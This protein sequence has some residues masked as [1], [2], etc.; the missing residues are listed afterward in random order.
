MI[1]IKEKAWA[2]RRADVNDYYV[3]TGKRAAGLCMD[4]DGCVLF[5]PL[6][7]E[8]SD[9]YA[10]DNPVACIAARRDGSGYEFTGCIRGGKEGKTFF[11]V[12]LTE[13]AETAI[14]IDGMSSEERATLADNIHYIMCRRIDSCA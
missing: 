2:E 9:S 12:P 14:G 8:G 1:Y 10:I 3:L 13:A 5:F 4:K 6:L 11:T 7:D